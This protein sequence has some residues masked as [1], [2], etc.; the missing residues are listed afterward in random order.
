MAADG[1]GGASSRANRLNFIDDHAIELMHLGRGDSGGAWGPIA[2]ETVLAALQAILD[3]SNYPLHVMC[4]FGR[5][6]TGPLFGHVE[7]APRR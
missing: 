7:R 2:E 4:N 1:G 5:H 3:P 6:P